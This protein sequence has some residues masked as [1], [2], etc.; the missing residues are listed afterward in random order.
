MINASSL[1]LDTMAGINYINAIFEVLSSPTKLVLVF[2]WFKCNLLLT[3]IFAFL[4]AAL[5]V[6]VA[7]NSYKWMFAISSSG[8]IYGVLNNGVVSSLFSFYTWTPLWAL[9]FIDHNIFSDKIFKVIRYVFNNS[10]RS[11]PRHNA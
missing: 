11:F 5:K 3:R 10:Y 4:F 8:I 6:L 1:R 9:F 7:K 2:S